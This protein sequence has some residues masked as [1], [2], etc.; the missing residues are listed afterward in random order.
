MLRAD[1]PR[2][3]SGHRGAAGEIC[4][5]Q[6]IALAGFLLTLAA[7]WP[8]YLS[9]DSAYQWWQARGA[10]LDPAH[11]PVMVHLWRAVRAVLPDPGGMLAVQ[12]AVWWA[13]IALFANAL[14]G[15]AWR[16]AGTVAL[17]GAWPPLLALLPH[18]WKDV[19]M[20]ALFALA[21]AC[22]AHDAAAP[23][24]RWRVAALVALALGCAFRLNALSAALPLL[25]WIAWREVAPAPRRGARA[26]RVA[27][28][29]VALLIVTIL[30][31]LGVNRAPGKDVP[32]WPAVALWDLAA[33]SIE[34]ERLLFPPVWVDPALTV[35][36]LRRDF[37]PYV[38]VPSF[39]HGQLKLNFYFDYTPAQFDELR[40]AWLALPFE[41][42]R[43][44]WTHRARLSAYLFGLRQ[45]E[46]PDGLVIS[47]GIVAFADNPPLAPNDGALHRV[48]QPALSRLVDTPVFAAWPYLVASLALVIA[49]LGWRGGPAWRE[50][51]GAVAASGL[52]LAAPLAVL[53]PS[54]DFRYLL[55][56]VFA[57]LLA[58][59]LWFAPR[60][61]APF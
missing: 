59:A 15:G 5:E 42:P 28:A 61:P 52:C 58:A 27:L 54:S 9:W 31:S 56:S 40:D 1:F 57:A 17:I 6:I 3:V 30:V 21:V 25:G 20:A 19:G 39:E 23:R 53:S 10:P 49:A 60:R 22:L 50:L 44:Y 36:D 51:A 29:A 11:P 34:E 16:R 4:S 12:A 26:W 32:V 13:A 7:F 37:V 24:R 47:P 18:L 46:H 2:S 8:G 14:G 38:N 45:G 41:H 35:A 48:V 33:V 43:A 55:W